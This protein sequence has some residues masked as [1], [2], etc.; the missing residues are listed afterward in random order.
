[1]R[2]ASEKEKK[3][4]ARYIVGY[5]ASIG[6]C[7]LSVISLCAS[8]YH[9]EVF[10]IVFNGVVTFY[11]FGVVCGCEHSLNEMRRNLNL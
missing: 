4:Y 8:I 9:K 7:G 10:W 6:L 11:W 1:M 5:Y 2:K 3:Q